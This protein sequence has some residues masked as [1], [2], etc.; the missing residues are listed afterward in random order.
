MNELS[1]WL[2]NKVQSFLEEEIDTIVGYYQGSLQTN[3]DY[4]GRQIHLSRDCQ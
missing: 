3:E 2:E 4:R 1:S